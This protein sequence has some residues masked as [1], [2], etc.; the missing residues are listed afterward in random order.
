MLVCKHNILILVISEPFQATDKIHRRALQLGFPNF[1]SNSEMGGKVWLC[2]KE[3]INMDL[4]SMTNQSFSR[5]FLHNGEVLLTPFI[6][7]KCSLYERR[8]LWNYLSSI[9]CTGVS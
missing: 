1:G 6:Y 4:V 7:A 3:E 9:S 2:W 8:D 5:L